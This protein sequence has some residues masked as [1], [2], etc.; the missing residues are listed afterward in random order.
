MVTAALITSLFNLLL[1]SFGYFSEIIDKL[2]PN[3]LNGARNLAPFLLVVLSKKKN[4]FQQ[5]DENIL[6]VP[7]VKLKISAQ[8]SGRKKTKRGNTALTALFILSYGSTNSKNCLVY[9]KTE[10]LVNT[11]NISHRRAIR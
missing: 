6:P 2:Q 10:L 9:I 11:M 8:Q 1:K 5:Y 3:K 7:G 4:Q